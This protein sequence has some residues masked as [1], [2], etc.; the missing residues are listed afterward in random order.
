MIL[1]PNAYFD[2]VEDITIEFL[3]KNK[4]KVL[5]LDVDNTLI[6]YKKELSQKVIN[7]VNDMKGQGIKLYILS[8][9]NDKQKV[10][11][12]ANTLGVQYKY[13][14]KKPL[15]SGFLKIQKELGEEP[16]KIGVVGDQ[17]FTDIIGGNRCKMFTIL[18]EPIDKKEFW[19]TAWKRPLENKIKNK[20]RETKE[21]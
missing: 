20:F 2:G 16:S 4:I 6:N 3:N 10:E 13:F 11:K 7:W 14:A 19:Y 8:N 17:I 12:L 18:V 15:K 5:I 9:S 1:Y 21:K